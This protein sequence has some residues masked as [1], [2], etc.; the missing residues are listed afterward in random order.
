MAKKKEPKKLYVAASTTEVA[1]LQNQYINK[2]ET[3]PEYSLEVDPTDKYSMT[4]DQK[5]FIRQYVQ[6]KNIP[7]ACQLAGID[8][9]EGRSY[10]LAYSS[11]QEIR[12]IN[13]AMYHRQFSTKLLNLD[14]IGGYLTSLLIDENVPVTDRLETKDKLKVAQM[15][16]DL[17]E[18][19]RTAFSDPE[20]IDAVEVSEQIKDLSVKSIKQL[21]SASHN[22][23]PDKSKDEIIERLDDEN[24]L[25]G[26]E[27]AYLKTLPVDQLL[28][29]L[30]NSGG[31]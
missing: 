28:Q 18:L 23:G 20:V 7:L 5:E 8:E 26:E 15:I 14:E 12:R 10:Y 9:K 17:N 24:N 25:S 29:L 6:F 2:I 13:L 3:D 1:E 11:Q 22:D 4:K 19:K 21:I 16:I 31:E 30:E 27:I